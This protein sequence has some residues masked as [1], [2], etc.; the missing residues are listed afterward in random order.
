MVHSGYLQHSRLTAEDNKKRNKE[1]LVKYM[2][3]SF[4]FCFLS[5]PLKK[6]KIMFFFSFTIVSFHVCKILTVLVLF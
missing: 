2:Y 1:D 5:V 4:P 6:S 3:V